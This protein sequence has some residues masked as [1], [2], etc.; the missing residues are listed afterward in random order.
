MA[1][2]KITEKDVASSVQSGAHFLVTQSE[3]VGGVETEALRRATL[4]QVVSALRQNG[5]NSGYATEAEMTAKI[6]GFVENIEGSNDGI[7]VFYGDGGEADIEIKTGLAFAGWEYDEET[8]YLHLVDANGDDVIEPVYIPGG[9]GGGSSSFIPTLTNNLPSRTLTVAE[10]NTV[11]L[12]F[13]YTSVDGD[14]ADDGA[15]SGQ[16]SVGGVVAERISVPQGANTVDITA[17]LKSGTNS[18]KLRVENSEGAYKTLTYTVVVVALSVTTT[19]KEIDV[20]SGDA[21]F[22]YTVFGSGSKTVHFTVDGTEIFQEVV[23]STGRSRTV[24]IPAQ[25]HGAH[26][27]ECW[28]TAAVS[29]ETVSSNRIRL[30]MV[31]LD[32]SNSEP[33]IASTYGVESVTQGSTVAISYLVIDPTSDTAE[34]ELSVIDGEGETYSSRTVTRDRSVGE[35]WSVQDYPAGTTTFSIA[36]RTAH[37]D[38]TLAVAPYTFPINP[39]TDSL[40]MEFSAE[41]RSNQEANPASWN[42]GDIEAEFTGFAWMNADGWMQDGDNAPVLRFLPGDSMTIPFKPFQSDARQTGYT[43]EVEMATRDVRDY[44]S[45]VLTCMSGGKGFRIAS[46]SASLRSEQSSVS[47]LFKEDS[48]VAVTF[49][50][51]QRNLNR[52]IYIYINGIMCGIAQYPDND[53]FAQSDPVGLTIGSES[54]GLDLY[55]MRFYSKGL[56]RAEQLDNFIC[57]RSTLGERR[58]AY[59]RNDILSEAEEVDMNRLPNTLPY[60]VISC[61]E[62]PQSKGDKKSGVRFTFVDP[63]NSARSFTAEGSMDVQGTSSAVYPVKNFKPKMSSFVINGVEATKYQLH[64]GALPV[65]TFCLKT[66]YASC[67]GANNVELVEL[68]ERVCRAHNFLTPPQRQDSRVR[69]G[70]AG[71][72][73]VV[74]W[75]N[76][77]ANTTTFVGKYNFNNDKSTENVFGFDLYEDTAESWEFRNNTTNHCLFKS[78]DFTPGSWENDFEAR[79]PEES[80]DTTRLKRVFDFVVAHNRETISTEA[81]KEA[82]LADFKA[83]FSEYFDQNLTLFYYIFTE[84]FLMVDSRAKNMFLTTYDGTHWLPIPYDMDTALGINNEGE[85]SFEY[86][87][88]DTDSVDGKQVFNGQTSVLWCNVRDAFGPEIRSMYNALRSGSVFNYQAVREMFEAHQAVWPERL[89]NEDAFVK[90]LA[91]YLY[92]GQD[93]LDMLQGDKSS[94]RDWWLFNA[95]RYRDS[96]YRTGDARTNFINFRAYTDA[97]HPIS[98]ANITVTPYSHIWA[99]V[100]YASTYTPTRRLKR[101]ESF[102]FVNPMDNMWDTEIHIYSADC[103]NDVGD[104]SAMNL[105]SADFSAATKLNRLIIGKDDPDYVNEHLN[106]LT[107]GNNELLT[108]IN[109]CN[110]VALTTPLDLSS[111]TGIETV[112]AKGSALT[113]VSLPAGGHL[114]R[115][116]LPD[117]IRNLTVINQVNLTEFSAEG[118]GVMT[119]LRIENTPNVPIEDILT[120]GES[121]ERVRLMGVSWAAT[122]ETALESCIDRLDSCG[123]LD[124]SGNNT[125]SAVVNGRVE[126]DS[127]SNELLE[128]IQSDYPDLV[129]VVD[130]V[131]Q[132]LVRFYNY[133]NALL[134]TEVVEEGGAVVDPVTAGE[135]STPTK[136]ASGTTRFAFDGWGAVPAAVTGNLNLVAVYAEEYQ[137]HYLNWD[138]TALYE[139]YVRRGSDAVYTGSTPTRTPDQ[140]YTYSFAG[141]TGN[142]ANVT[143]ERSFTATYESADRTYTV[144]FARRA[145]DGGGTLQTVTG[146]LYGGSA[147]YTG[148]TPTTAR[149]TAADYPFLG[150]NPEPT[151]IQGDTTCYAKFDWVYE[152]EITDSWADI[153]AAIG[154]GSYSHRYNVGNYKP[155]DL[156]AQGVVN[157]Q[158]VAMDT[159]PLADGSG[160][161]HLTWI[162]KELLKDTHLMNPPR[163]RDPEDSSKYEEGTGSIGGWEKTEMRS[164]LKDTI[165]PLIPE[166][167][168]N[169]LL[170]VTKYSRIYN[171]SNVVVDN[172]GST[173]DVWVPSAREVGITGYETSGPTYT[174]VFADNASRVKTDVSSG[175]AARWW[176]RSAS[177]GSNFSNVSSG[178][179][180][181]SASA[182]ASGGVA[183]GF[184][185]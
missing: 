78:A 67:E 20:Y 136:P 161:A 28:A 2:R 18:V 144:T 147:A 167:V 73:I 143:E 139:P 6:N 107:V 66:D 77:A 169:A 75:N 128:R 49:V 109:V 22:N 65:S 48:R 83:H 151:S 23:T 87:L 31:W 140:R 64:D 29:S 103:L 96:K 182:N 55:R 106:S 68:Y 43:I 175:S 1:T 118:Y 181:S 124:A 105:G 125:A 150:W 14:G 94:Q 131:A 117:T 135:I 148:E 7:K 8:R 165:K 114:E 17:L 57:D 159:D 123:G 3:N 153:L 163:A 97:S 154:D 170:S 152:I 110:C 185:L 59:E 164:Y 168:R 138:G 45:L 145:V 85:L 141:W 11:E 51:E 15:G 70:I 34:V 184:C 19:F 41:G 24:T 173:E 46:Q 146:I 101:G 25:G 69:Q 176:L 156:G 127:I 102:T 82:M 91:P 58:S 62:L 180:S 37:R 56:N 95:F 160:K 132:Y 90:Y 88:E 40:E 47:M 93:Y 112:L 72:P 81:E 129:V 76:T 122:D 116:Q 4:P 38:F 119:T 177:N 16:I 100:E 115:L 157:M 74:F 113:G 179:S 36:C 80:T 42:Y 133:D 9:G 27:F 171:T 54:C 120:T 26:L 84:V 121:L 126:I 166:A 13:T 44:E 39:I 111:C 92:N 52:F 33:V 178:G 130:G 98:A 10:G 108:L 21:L 89:W 104:L 142:Q 137:V 79:F 30:S 158:I 183:L 35:P 155:L 61:P 60:M 162:S 53:N 134:Y 32:P 86:D 172:V 5:V 149:G 50:V 174:T 99:A 12:A 71:R 63:A